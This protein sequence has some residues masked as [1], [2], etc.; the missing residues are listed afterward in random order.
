ME[1]ICSN[2]TMLLIGH[3]RYLSLVQMTEARMTLGIMVNYKLVFM[4]NFSHTQESVLH[5]VESNV[6]S[7]SPAVRRNEVYPCCSFLQQLPFVMK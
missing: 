4:P 7:Q 5:V 3:T 6:L 1:V 2:F